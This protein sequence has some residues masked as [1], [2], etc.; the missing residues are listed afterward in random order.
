MTPE[1]RRALVACLLAGTACGVAPSTT[2][3]ENGSSAPEHTGPLLFVDAL[4]PGQTS[5]LKGAWDAVRESF[6][7]SSCMTGTQATS[8]PQSTGTI[9]LQR[10]Q[11]SASVSSSLGV[12]VNAKAR[13]GLFDGSVKAQYARSTVSNDLTITT[14][15]RARFDTALVSLDQQSYG[16]FVDPAN[17]Q[18]YSYCGD[19]FVGSKHVGGEFWIRFT[20]SFDTLATKQSFA[21][22]SRI[23]YASSEVAGSVQAASA[24]Y[25]G[26][27]WVSV[28]AMQVGGLVT[29]LSQIVGGTD[30]QGVRA[31]LDC[32]IDNLGACTQFMQ[33]GI[34]YATTLNPGGFIDGVQMAPADLQYE[35]VRYDTAY[36]AGA[37]TAAPPYRVTPSAVDAARASLQHLLDENLALYDRINQLQG[38]G[39]GSVNQALASQLTGYLIQVKTNIAALQTV[40]PK[41]WDTLNLQDAASV[42][43]CMSAPSSGALD[44]LGYVSGLSIPQLQTAVRIPINRLYR[45]GYHLFSL[46]TTEGYSLGYRLEIANNFYT[47]KS[48][49]DGSV[50]IYRCRIN[51]NGRYLMTT[52]ASCEGAGNNEGSFGYI[53]T[54]QIDGAVPLYRWYNPGNGDR[55]VT[56]TSSQPASGWRYEG[57]TGYAWT[58]P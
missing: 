48:S 58:T 31:F 52:S 24:S 54:T 13:I 39:A 43:V 29:N 45:P 20:I 6:T 36:V 15:Y 17:P 28:D 47:E 10:Q 8:T 57:I 25:K 2:E 50:P 34:A 14:Y 42:S 56:L 19:Q 37:T 5:P 30:G 22:D 26:K 23:S 49:R 4:V 51:G 55:L 27:A 1:I 53:M 3:T 40:W 9:Q 46:S 18:W 21:A 12:S 11:D 16:Y 35:L 44:S 41:C 32:S 33:N 7:G 38:V